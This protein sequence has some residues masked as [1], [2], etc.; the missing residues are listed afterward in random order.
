MSSFDQEKLLVG[1]Q[2]VFFTSSEDMHFI[3]DGTIDFIM[4]STQSTEESEG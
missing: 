4:T 3:E 1:N 2:Q